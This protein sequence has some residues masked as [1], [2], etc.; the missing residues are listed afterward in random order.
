MI[1]WLSLLLSIFAIAVALRQYTLSKKAQIM[2]PHSDR[3]CEVFESWIES[4][5]FLPLIIDPAYSHE[6]GTITP[7]KASPSAL[8]FALQHLQTGYPRIYSKLKNLHGQI[9]THNQKAEDFIAGLCETARKK[10]G[11]SK[12]PR[13][14]HYAYYYRLVSFV[15]R[16]M[17]IGYPEAEP[18]ITSIMRR[19][20]YVLRWNGADLVIGN[21]ENCENGLKLI[22]KL[23][24]SEEI[25]SKAKIFHENAKKLNINVGKLQETLRL[26]LIDNIKVG[27]I[28]K[29]KC[30][31]CE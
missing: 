31:A 14:K 6:N 13:E 25:L 1:E 16:K 19:Q 23:R 22:E 27:G 3:L 9:E 4:A 11:L 30:D 8:P 26:K 20:K 12:T 15:L 2:R 5:N 28:I 7:L 18:E 10:I 29:G 24:T 21:R 17:L